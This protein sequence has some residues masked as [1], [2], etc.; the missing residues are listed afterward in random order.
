M[1][2]EEKKR[3]AQDLNERFSKA[4][5]IIVTD[6]KGLDVDAVNDLRRRLRKAE[7]EYQVVKNSL[8]MRASQETDVAGIKE[9]FT[10]P[11]AVALG[12]GDPAAPAKVLTEFAKDHEMFKIKIGITG[13]RILAA[14][15][16]AALAALPSREV[17]LGQ[18]LSV[19]NNVPSGFVRTLAE[20]PR[21]LV[22]VLRAIQDQKEAA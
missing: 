17:L 7:V 20:I 13:G 16:I 21:R 15:E 11:S 10:G 22:N 8:L 18:F 6:Y 19:L 2:I 12:Y 5:V 14:K 4:A 3:I 1:N 9:T